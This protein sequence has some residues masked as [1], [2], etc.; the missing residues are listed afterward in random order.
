MSLSE[1]IPV[2]ERPRRGAAWA[3]YAISFAS[4]GIATLLAVAVDRQIRACTPA[5][6]AWTTYAGDRLK[7]GPVTAT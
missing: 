3:A 6:G 5:P 4:V 1:L 7:L 2:A